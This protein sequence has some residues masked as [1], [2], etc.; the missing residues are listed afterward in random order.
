MTGVGRGP[1][2]GWISVCLLA[3]GLQA[4]ALA[5]QPLW[6]L[7]LASLTMLFGAVR[8]AQPVAAAWYG[9]SF[10]FAWMSASLWWLY[11]AMHRYGGLP[12][13]LS[14]LSVLLLA[15]V[16]ALYLAG[17]M[18]AQAR[19]RALHPLGSW[20]GFIAWWLLAE[21][22]RGVWFTGFPWA[23]SGYAQI[24]GPLQGLAAWVGVYG[25]GAA[26][27]MLA[28]APWL[29]FEAVQ[30]AAG[31]RQWLVLAAV[32]GLIGPL[33]LAHLLPQGFT[34]P[35]SILRVSLLQ[36]NVPQD[37]KFAQEHVGQSLEWHRQA[38]L[39]AQGDLVLAPETAIALLPEQLPEGWWR[40]LVQHF[41]QGHTY[42][43]FGV[44]LGNYEVG[45][46]NSVVGVTPA[47]DQLY[48]YDK[49][50]LLPFGEFI[51]PGFHWFVAMMNMPLGDFN[52]G[53]LNAPSFRVK[54]ER[55]A[56]SI[57]YE[58]LFGEE[59]A[60]RFADEQSAPTLLANVSNLGWYD[61]STAVPQHLQFSRMRAL[62]FQRPMIRAT[63][64]GAT[65][66]IDHHGRVTHALAPYTQGV[67]NGEVQGRTGLTPYARWVPSCGLWPLWLMAL[68]VAWWPVWRR[69]VPGRVRSEV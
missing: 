37:E 48:R 57:C 50:H 60:L 58:D 43:L 1:G 23:A 19:W 54:A 39:A 29:L 33:G 34:Q 61:Q 35:T 68:G 52:R 21:L 32:L 8:C 63:N 22:A 64:T 9:G 28:T 26:A 17:A 14:V 36:G 66:I 62:E 65:V 30:A 20:A 15:A 25:I 7:Q 10:G 12:A 56:P 49:A 69:F 44:P 40:E 11:T 13:W 2:F 51:P 27:A 55:V 38:L 53:A 42:A 67:L 18:A 24:D 16:L 4:L 47:H 3:G 59:L 5:P 45:Y 6:W 31:Q 46:T 41:V